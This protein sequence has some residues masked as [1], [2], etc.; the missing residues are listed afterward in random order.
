MNP[1]RWDRRAIYSDTADAAVDN[2]FAYW[3]VLV[4][5]GAIATLGLAVD[6]P[7]V[8]IG[9][10]LVAPLLGP[11][12]GL[13]LALAVG[14]S[15]LALQS[16][17]VVGGSLI[18]V[19]A[20]AAGLTLL[21]PF[22]TLTLEITARIHPTT[23]DL[24]I[25]VC[26]GLVGALVTVVRGSRLSTAIPGV[27]VAVALIPPLAVAGFG[28]G[29]GWQGR[30]I[31][32]ALLLLGANLAG[33]VLSGV[34]VFL[35]VGMHRDD[36][37]LAARQ[38]HAQATP[39]GI[40]RLVCRL[41]VVGRADV[42]GSAVGRALLVAGFVALLA[43]P[44]TAAL[45]EV[46]RESRV[47]GAVSDALALLETD[48]ATSILWHDVELGADSAL[49]RVR[50]ATSVGVGGE[51]REAFRRRASE[52]AGEPIRLRLEQLP[53]A[54]GDAS[55]L[56]ALLRG[57]QRQRAEADV[58]W[59]ETLGRARTL[60]EQAAWSLPWPAGVHAVGVSLRLD[61]SLAAGS[62]SVEVVYLGAVPLQA[63]TLDVLANVLRR[64]VG[65]AEL[66]VTFAR[67]GP[68]VVELERPNN[69][70][71]SRADMAQVL[72]SD[73]ALDTV[74]RV[75]R[76]YPGL[77]PQITSAPGDSV[78]RAAL[79]EAIRSTGVDSVLVRHRLDPGPV[80]VRVRGAGG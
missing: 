23:L 11:I 65:H 35:V 21:L 40:A 10:M 6:S 80:E 43:V 13:S 30:V 7:A 74:L 62:D 64:S 51:A 41:P 15:R 61:N 46:V 37:V 66:R 60:L 76:R 19:M 16:A 14:D 26:S 20:T 67:A 9:A 29:A 73:A 2:G 79:L 3:S 44:L 25:A 42:F 5:S 36:A 39:N 72:E 28:M 45:K 71:V 18:V 47:R 49:A 55:S 32:G 48:G 56:R 38:W 12:M 63:Q 54:A 57:G 78:M 50:V 77:R 17:A 69:A 70:P 34:V 22:R 33:I 52:L 4:L 53:A 58:A 1:M 59:P 8:V 31:W 27:A 68:A 75:L 24:G